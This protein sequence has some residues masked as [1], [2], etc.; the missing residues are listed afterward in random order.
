MDSDRDGAAVGFVR[1]S[2]AG[3]LAACNFL[4]STFL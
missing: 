4:M 1:E 2:S 3:W